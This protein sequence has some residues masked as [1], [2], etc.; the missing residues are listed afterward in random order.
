MHCRQA[1]KRLNNH[2]WLFASYSQDSELM[3]HLKK[4]SLCSSLVQAEEALGNDLK[5]VGRNEP[6]GN[7]SLETLKEKAELS[8]AVSPSGSWRYKA[9]MILKSRT[10][11][12]L[13]VGLAVVVIAFLAFVPFNFTE[14]VGYEIAVSG[15][16]RNIA[17]DNR[18]IISLLDALGLEE[19]KA[20]TLL[21]SI[22]IN[23]IHLY[24]GECRETC[25]LKI[26]DL[27]TEKDVRLVVQAILDLGCCEIDN[28]IPIF[29]NE[30]TSLL[31]H[32]TK[33]IFS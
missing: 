10:R 5:T 3:E 8:E 21:D 9:A 22:Q 29:R 28:I 16:D 25:H 20:A 11:H 23:E 15:I 32:A 30:S 7:L 6:P 1:R 24:I 26:S 4:C 17:L 33:R 31:G 19:D 13:T 14:T 12:K 18:E 2:N 27:K